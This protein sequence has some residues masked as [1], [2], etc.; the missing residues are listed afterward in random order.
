MG[1]EEGKPRV[2]G[3]R[4]KHRSPYFGEGIGGS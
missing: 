1:K 2:R 4:G 3:G